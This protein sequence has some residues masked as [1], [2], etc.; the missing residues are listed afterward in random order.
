MTLLSNTVMRLL[1]AVL[2]ALTCGP[3]VAAPSG[4]FAKSGRI[5]TIEQWRSPG[6]IAWAVQD[7][8]I[9]VYRMF[10]YVNRSDEL[11]VVKPI[12]AE[13]S[14]AIREAIKKLPTDAFG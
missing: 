12:T 3:I 14:N 6:G 11:V 8:Q 1:V 9:V 5:L 2:S 4:D 10:D 7:R 13:Q